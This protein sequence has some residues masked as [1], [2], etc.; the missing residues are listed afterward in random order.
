MILFIT[1]AVKTS[2]PT[3]YHVIRY[4]YCGMSAE[5]RNS[6]PRIRKRQFPKLLPEVWIKTATLRVAAA[7]FRS[8][9]I[10]AFSPNVLPETTFAPCSVS[11][12]LLHC[13]VNRSQETRSGG[14]NQE[15]SATCKEAAI[16][17]PTLTGRS[18]REIMPSLK[19]DRKSNAPR[20][21][22]N[23]NATLVTRDLFKIKSRNRNKTSH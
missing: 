1:T 20:R 7:R 22:L 10:Y 6:G 23:P 18:V 5:G 14:N 12:R 4:Y 9:G 19:I 13:I 16:A 15:L 17:R 2:N 8:T 3:I 21:S 11:E